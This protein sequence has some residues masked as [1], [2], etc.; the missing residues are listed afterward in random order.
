MPLEAGRTYKLTVEYY[1]ATADASMQFAYRLT[2]VPMTP[3]QRDQIAK[4]DVAIVCVRTTESEGGDR[5]YGLGSEQDDLI[6]DTVALNPKTVV[7]LNAGGNV[8]MG[9]WVDKVPAV[10]DAWYAGQAGGRAIAEVAFGD[11]D[12]SG[13]L[14]DTFAKDWPDDA[15]FGHYPGNGKQV[16]YAEG[17]LV[18]YR[19]F[20]AKRI[21]PRF[22]FGFGLSYTTFDVKNISVKPSGD[23]AFTVAADVTNTGKRAGATVVQVYVRPPGDEKVDRP[24]QEL[25]AFAKVELKPGETRSVTMSLDSR[26]FA[27]WDAEKHGWAV[28]PGT[29]TVAVGQSSRDAHGTSTVPVN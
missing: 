23:R 25:K 5:L 27:H 13:H 9:A 4:A 2:T 18:G 24:V 21:E 26:S 15:A 7:V 19:W 8:G 20:D 29:Y 3:E 14:P 16:D 28:T 12:P 10:I 17:L 22:P 1:N 6:A 11:V